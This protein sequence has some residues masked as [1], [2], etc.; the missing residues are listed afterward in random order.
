MM[1]LPVSGD[2][3]YVSDADEVWDTWQIDGYW[4]FGIE[5]NIGA[6][7]RYID[8][9]G[10]KLD[11]Q[12]QSV[13]VYVSNS[14]LSVRVYA[15]FEGQEPVYDTISYQPKMRDK[16]LL[17]TAEGDRSCYG[18]AS[19]YGYGIDVPSGTSSDPAKVYGTV[20]TTYDVNMPTIDTTKFSYNHVTNKPLYTYT[21]K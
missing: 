4:C 10:Y 15:G 5:N 9:N 17:Y 21:V 11:T 1:V 18:S 8:I 13:L 12:K 2:L 7:T 20:E 14:V 6:K 16:L 19:G 3:V